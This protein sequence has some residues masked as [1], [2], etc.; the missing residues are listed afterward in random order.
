MNRWTAKK[1][2]LLWI[3]SY[4]VFC[5]TKSTCPA[6][7]TCTESRMF[8]EK[9][10]TCR[11]NTDPHY[12]L[13]NA[14]CIF[15]SIPAEGRSFIAEYSLPKLSLHSLKLADRSAGFNDVLSISPISK[16]SLT[17][18]SLQLWEVKLSA[19]LPIL[20]LVSLSP[21]IISLHAGY[22]NFSVAG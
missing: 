19:T 20:K 9:A 6:V 10:A 11:K 21:L 22:S 14:F 8:I 13:L 4:A 18:S 17:L 12:H 15:Y 5:V 1:T 16:L 7:Q 3:W 2:G